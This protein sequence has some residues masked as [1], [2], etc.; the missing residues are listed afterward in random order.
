[1]VLHFGWEVDDGLEHLRS[2]AG[3]LAGR[4][5][6]WESFLEAVDSSARGAA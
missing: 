2:L 6:T 3:T 4:A 1:V 5:V